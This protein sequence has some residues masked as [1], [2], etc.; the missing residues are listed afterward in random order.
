MSGEQGASEGNEYH[1]IQA[2]IECANKEVGWGGAVLQ[3]IV[4]VV[5]LKQMNHPKQKIE[6]ASMQARD[7]LL[8]PKGANE[9][10]QTRLWVTLI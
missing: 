4:Q 2:T 6:Q 9:L 3:D 1:G 5:E 7:R 10:G 8:L